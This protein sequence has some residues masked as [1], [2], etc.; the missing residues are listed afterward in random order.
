MR[1]KKILIVDDMIVSLM[2]TENMLCGHYTTF[3]ASSGQ[4]AIEIYRRE[5]PDM[6][7]SDLRMPGMS[8]YELQQTLQKEMQQNIPFMFMT[9]DQDEDTES[10]GFENGAM[11]FIRKPFRPDVLLRRVGN[12]MQTVDQIE[13]LKKHASTDPL[14]GLLNKVSAEVEL[15][16]VC[17]QGQGALLM[18]DLDSFKL[19]NDIYGHA[20]G[21]KVLMSF[22]DIL[23]VSVRPDDV[24]GRLGGD[25]FIAF[26]S[27]MSDEPGI[28]NKAASINRML[29]KSARELM[30]EDMTIPLGASIGCVF[31]QPGGEEFPE[32]AQKADKA[33][34]MAKQNGKHGCYI[35]RED[36]FADSDEAAALA[37][38]E[39]ILGER[40]PANGALRLPFE[41]FRT[42]YRFLRRTM[43]IFGK[44]VS[45]L[46]FYL[47][48]GTDEK[49]MEAFFSLLCS[50]LRT[51]DVA[52]QNGGHCLVLLVNTSFPNLAHAA[53]RLRKK[54]TEMEI[55]EGMEADFEYEWSV[56]EP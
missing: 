48:N 34:Y 47:P 54:W 4:E 33:L 39:K 44:P 28:L 9:A 16:R 21:D 42:V 1:M 31:V 56:L 17:G 36:S 46:R 29:D 45:I 8:G 14:T 43:G 3:S 55:E 40:N 15:Q 23:R 52:T 37:K 5:H 30:G 53:D 18:I 49:T 20:M 12:I 22:A 50:T 6:V 35:F 27:G 24:V 11:D 32:L 13:G 7:L 25:E 2:M 19:V 41:E 10:R 26:C 51:A 38:V